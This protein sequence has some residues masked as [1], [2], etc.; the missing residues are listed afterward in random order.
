[1]NAGGY[2]DEDKYA[3]AHVA[4]VDAMSSS[5]GLS[6]PM[7]WIWVPKAPDPA[8]SAERKNTVFQLKGIALGK[9][10]PVRFS[11]GILLFANI[12]FGKADL[13]VPVS[14]RG[15]GLARGFS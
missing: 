1:M 2:L 7:S 6:N 9:P 5:K 11:E 13:L 8:P 4:M 12:A 10:L 3:E 14:I 15:W